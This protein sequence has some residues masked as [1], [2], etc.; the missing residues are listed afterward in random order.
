MDG[1]KKPIV[2][3][4]K[5]KSK[6]SKRRERSRS[7]PAVPIE[8]ATEEMPEDAMLSASDDEGKGDI[9]PLGA[10]AK[11]ILDLDNSALHHVDLSVPVGEDEHLPRAKPY[12]KPEELRQYE[13]DLAQRRRVDAQQAKKEEKSKKEKKSKR[14][15]SAEGEDRKKSK[16]SKK[17]KS[18]EPTSVAEVVPVAEPVRSSKP[19]SPAPTPAPVLVEVE[20]VQEKKSKKSSKSAG[21]IKKSSSSSKKTPKAPVTVEFPPRTNIDLTHDDNVAV[22]RCAANVI[23]DESSLDY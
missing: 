1:F 18:K 12:M 3:R 17:S 22:V 21:K 11:G 4:K 8:F 6:K 5:E 20:E 19:S 2:M 23:Q 16:S 13:D 14:E 15:T 10:A 9:K 7:P